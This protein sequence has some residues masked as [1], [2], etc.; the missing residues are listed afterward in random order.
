MKK[1]KGESLR[2]EFPHKKI[3]LVRHGETEWTLSGK[4]TGIT[5]I[6]L[7]K[8]GE[9]EAAHLCKRLKGYA[10]QTVLSSPLQ[11]AYRTCE[12]SGFSKQ[13]R[14]DPDL[15]EWNYGQFEGL[16]T[17]EIWKQQPHWNLFTNGAPNG[18]NLADINVRTARVLSKIQSLRG[19]VLLFSHGHFL[20]TL[21]AKWLQLPIQDGKLL[22]LFP[23]SVSILGFERN[24][25]VLTLWNDVSHLKTH[26]DATH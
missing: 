18:E 15:T 16:T 3:Y 23:A 14:L 13:A 10:F 22:A 17:E 8:N 7:T 5:D 1:S 6:P 25:H 11:R 19:D 24:N 12:I 26:G 4:H 2:L 21:A 9:E 20:R